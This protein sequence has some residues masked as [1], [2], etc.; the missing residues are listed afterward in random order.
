MAT[1]IHLLPSP[2][3]KNPQQ[4]MS[5]T[6]LKRTLLKVLFLVFLMLAIG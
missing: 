5:K 3:A 6:E 2:E 1:L 4:Q